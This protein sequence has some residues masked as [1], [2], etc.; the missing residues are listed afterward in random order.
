MTK[1]FAQIYRTMYG[2]AM[3]VYLRETPT[4]AAENKCKQLELTLAIYATDHL[5]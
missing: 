1:Y 3:L 5:N 4:V 2:A